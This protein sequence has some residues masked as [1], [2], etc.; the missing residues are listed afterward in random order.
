MK[1]DN[2]EILDNILE[3]LK[4]DPKLSSYVKRISH[5]DMSV[6]R[7]IF[8]FIDVGNFHI[9]QDKA[10]T[11][12][13]VLTYMIEIIAG[14]KSLAPGVAREGAECGGV[15]I[16]ELCD[17]ICDA[18]RG[19]AFGRCFEPAQITNADPDHTGSDDETTRIG[20]VV[21]TCRQRA[22]V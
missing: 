16:V 13:V 9:R 11:G 6:S 20:L 4:S 17:D 3:A 10:T 8:P 2:K 12:S 1:I 5:G 21:I 18:L 22:P 19:R 7:K 14:T 15:G